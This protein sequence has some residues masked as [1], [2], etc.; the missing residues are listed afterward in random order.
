[1]KKLV[2]IIIISLWA[3]ASLMA[4]TGP[5]GVGNSSN[6]ILWLKADAITGVS[7]G[8]S[9]TDWLDQSGNG[10]NF[11]QTNGSRKPKWTQSNADFN[12]RPTVT[13]DGA[14]DYFALVTSPLNN[15]KINYTLFFV[16]KSTSTANQFLH[17]SQKGRLKI[18][19]YGGG[20]RAF[21]DGRS[22]ERR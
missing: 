6:N 15:S 16:Y 11:T 5:G 13:F 3:V 21:H 18:P 17:D 10:N 14:D 8:G 4:Q 7:D 19:H 1:M 20:D 9:I 22:E 2:S 12:G